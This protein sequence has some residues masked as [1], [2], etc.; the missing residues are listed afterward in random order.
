L[1]Q[2]EGLGHEDEFT[3]DGD[4]AFARIKTKIRGQLGADHLSNHIRVW[5]S[6]RLRLYELQPAAT[7]NP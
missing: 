5:E 6:E 2:V 1:L 4:W 3:V 7:T